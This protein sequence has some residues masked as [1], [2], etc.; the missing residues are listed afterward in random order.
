MYDEERPHQALGM[1]TPSSLYEP[2]PREYPARVPEPEYGSALKVRR[3]RPCGNFTW[4]GEDV[5]LSEVL[6]GEPVGLLPLDERHYRVY[7]ATF[8]LALFDSYE[9]RTKPLPAEQE[10]AEE[11]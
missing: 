6:T 3:V 2:S 5:F 10:E 1:Q 9:L 11:I 4:G 8:P 7:F